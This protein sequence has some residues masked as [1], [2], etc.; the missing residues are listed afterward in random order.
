MDVLR[1]PSI[2]KIVVALIGAVAG[3][4]TTVIRVR[5]RV[6]DDERTVDP[7][8]PLGLDEESLVGSLWRYIA[9][10]LRSRRAMLAIGLLSFVGLCS[11]GCLL[12]AISQSNSGS[13]NCYWDPFWGQW[14]CA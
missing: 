1:D 14:V 10:V 4:I 7:T 13:P 9:P 3:I 6:H 12:L 5:A 11:C 2:S 8:P